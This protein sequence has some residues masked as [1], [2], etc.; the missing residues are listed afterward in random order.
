M[1]LNYYPALVIILLL[2]NSCTNLD[3]V[4]EK[5][6]K[7]VKSNKNKK[8][9][10][11]SPN[12]YIPE[13]TKYLL[14]AKREKVIKIRGEKLNC[15]ILKNLKGEKNQKIIINQTIYYQVLKNRTKI[16]KNNTF[17]YTAI[18]NEKNKNIKAKILSK[19]KIE[20]YK[21]VDGKIYFKNNNK[22]KINNNDQNKNLTF[23]YGFQK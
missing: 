11:S 9:E 21:K 14:N 13:E 12:Y 7:I 1:R 20:P 2:F 16:N 8:T 3:N 10:A 19:I 17:V 5:T 18:V 4:N 23:Y 6:K 22:F 15:E